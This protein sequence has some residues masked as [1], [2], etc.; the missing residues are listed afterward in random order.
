MSTSTE[1]LARFMTRLAA[2]AQ[3]LASEL[4][5]GDSSEPI[6]EEGPPTGLGARQEAVYAILHG[7]TDEGLTTSEISQAMGGYDVPNTYLTLRRLEQLSLVEL[8]PGS[9]PQRWRLHPRQRG[10]AGP[11]LLAA[12]Q[13]RHGEWATYGDLSIAVRGNDKGARAVGRAAAT[14]P[15]F[16]NA[17]RILKA[18]GVIPP[19]WHADDGGGPE[20]CRQLLEAEGVTFSAEGRADAA[21]RVSWEEIRARLR[22]AGVAVPDGSEV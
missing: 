1:A 22:R 21:L 8:L 5:A 11:Y 16:P 10:T 3:D 2:A 12:Q 20:V 14:L 13:V 15:E 18:G 7:A 19:D 4:Q 9:K 6:E 17:H